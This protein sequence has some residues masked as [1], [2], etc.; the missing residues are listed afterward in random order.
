MSWEAAIY[1][2]L[3][4]PQGKLKNWEGEVHP[5]FEAI[6]QA[7]YEN[8]YQYGY[9]VTWTSLEDRFIFHGMIHRDEY[10]AVSKQVECLFSKSADFGGRGDII[11]LGITR[12]GYE[13]LR[14]ADGQ[15]QRMATTENLSQ[16]AYEL[17]AVCE[18]DPHDEKSVVKA[19]TRP[20]GVFLKIL[21][22]PWFPKKD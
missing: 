15:C 19:N 11:F 8:K 10:S 5:T 12:G 18:G 20:Q 17:V 4:F 16:L 3:V 6:R 14:I 13:R 22:Q 9:F 21:Q 2:E 1:G 7:G